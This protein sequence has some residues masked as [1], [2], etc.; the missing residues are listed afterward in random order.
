MFF[1]FCF[2]NLRGSLTQNLV[3][4]IAALILQC[5]FFCVPRPWIFVFVGPQILA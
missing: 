1:F 5:Y 2:V 4:K 3:G